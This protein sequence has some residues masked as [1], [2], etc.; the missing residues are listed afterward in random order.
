[1]QSSQSTLTSNDMYEKLLQKAINSTSLV[2]INISKLQTDTPDYTMVASLLEVFCDN[3]TEITAILTSGEKGKIDALLSGILFNPN[4][5][6][7]L[8]AYIFKSTK[9][10]LQSSILKNSMVITAKFLLKV[11]HANDEIKYKIVSSG[12]LLAQVSALSILSHLQNTDE[13]AA[14]LS[15]IHLQLLHCCFVDN[16][17]CI[18]YA[19]YEVEWFNVLSPLVNSDNKAVHYWSKFVVCHVYVALTG[20][21]KALIEL[22]STDVS[23]LLGLLND[24]ASSSE[25]NVR[26][27]EATISLTLF[28]LLHILS[29]FTVC[30]N[31]RSRIASDSS[32][33]PTLAT[34][35]V[36]ASISEKT[37]TCL[38]ILMLSKEQEFKDAFTLSELPFNDILCILQGEDSDGW[39]KCLIEST[40]NLSLPIFCV[41]KLKTLHSLCLQFDSNL[42]VDVQHNYGLL[43]SLCKLLEI[44]NFSIEDCQVYD[45][46]H[47]AQKTI[48]VLFCIVTKLLCLF[49][50][51]HEKLL[52]CLPSITCHILSWIH[53]Q[54]GF[55]D[56][57]LMKHMLGEVSQQLRLLSSFEWTW[58]T[59]FLVKANLGIIINILNNDNFSHISGDINW[60]VLLKPWLKS[61]SQNIRMAAM[62]IGFCLA[63]QFAREGSLLKPQESDEE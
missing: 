61:I 21:H 41:T 6:E 37:A 53:P 42:E 9:I 40:I 7:M 35:L 23:L 56:H 39:V 17:F 13:V 19:F 50:S 3:I 22:S 33:L 63:D 45:K 15:S 12:L 54:S 38:F 10:Y 20:S 46:E 8:F 36:S 57:I 32:L 51:N 11:T 24:A 47:Y 62:I 31:N 60:V 2:T 43:N 16:P 55:T 14:L 48:T 29:K 28:E 44:V 34:L 26:L 58:F 5:L 27:A 25:P 4:L 30:P 59:E 52:F 18:M 1:M 49:G